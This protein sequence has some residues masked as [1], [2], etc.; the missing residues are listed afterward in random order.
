MQASDAKATDATG[1][2]ATIESGAT[3]AYHEHMIILS[4]RASR[5]FRIEDSLPTH[6]MIFILCS[7]HIVLNCIY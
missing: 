6:M 4:A 7:G 2:I 5:V 1:M 3:G